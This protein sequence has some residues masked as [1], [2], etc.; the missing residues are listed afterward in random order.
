MPDS[1]NGFQ[2]TI[3]RAIRA[4]G[5][6][7]TMV[8]S[9]RVP[10][11]IYTTGLFDGGSEGHELILA[12]GAVFQANDA[13][14]LVDAAARSGT[15]SF[16]VE[17]AGSFHLS[18]VDDSWVDS[19][20]LA[21]KRYHGTVVPSLQIVPDSPSID[22]PDMSVRWEPDQ[23]PVWQ[24]MDL[25]RTVPVAASATAVT[26]VGALRGNAI[27]EA[28]RWEQDQWELFS[29]P[30]PE[31]SR[32]DARFVPLLTLLGHDASLSAL[33]DLTVGNGLRR[34][35]QEGSWTPWTAR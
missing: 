5:Y 24:W 25:S 32:D 18:P 33:L 4:A 2:R 1:K 15:Q 9:G 29:V 34:T 30:A 35:S 28:V 12:G 23:E 13:R 21:A 10:R 22:V 6:H 8:R 19:L 26:D 31:L 20:L 14:G 3:E 16:D 11:C 27:V 7:V 17:G